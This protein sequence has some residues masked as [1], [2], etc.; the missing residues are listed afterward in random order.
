ML[1]RRILFTLL[2]TFGLSNFACAGIEDWQGMFIIEGTKG[3]KSVALH[4]PDHV[5]VGFI[6]TDRFR[7]SKGSQINDL[8]AKE[9]GVLSYD[10]DIDTYK[11]ELSKLASIVES[12]VNPGPSYP[13]SLQNY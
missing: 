12:N 3:T 7:F 6:R 8:I 5:I 2:L 1:F 4:S 11:H 13:D 10:M 9:D